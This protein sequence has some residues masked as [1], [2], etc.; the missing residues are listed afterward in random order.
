MHTVRPLPT[1]CFRGGTDSTARN[2]PERADGSDAN[3]DSPVKLAHAVTQI[4]GI[5]E[6]APRRNALVVFLYLLGAMFL[7]SLFSQLAGMVPFSTGYVIST[8]P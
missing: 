1:A 8:T 7:A 4:P 6:R 5:R 2:P 3:R